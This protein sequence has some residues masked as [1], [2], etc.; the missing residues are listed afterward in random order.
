M[1]FHSCHHTRG[2]LLLAGFQ[3][4]APRIIDEQ[5][6]GACRLPAHFQIDR[7][8]RV[9]HL[10][11][12][13]PLG[14]GRQG[15]LLITLLLLHAVK[16]QAAAVL[17]HRDTDFCAGV[18]LFLAR[19][20]RQFP[21]EDLPTGVAPQTLDLVLI[22]RHRR[23]AFDPNDDFRRHRPQAPLAAQGA[24]I[25]RFLAANRTDFH[26]RILIRA[27]RMAPVAFPPGLFSIVGILRPRSG[28][29][30][31]RSGFAAPRRWRGIRWRLLGLIFLGRFPKQETRQFSHPD[32]AVF[33][34]PDQLQQ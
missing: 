30:F 13:S 9:G 8:H 4:Q 23:T 27:G 20:L 21:L 16:R 24:S 6:F 25:S 29:A 10:L 1:V 34:D 31:S 15:N 33:H 7:K 18:V 12:E 22:R 2:E 17:H 11:D 26:R 14:S 28:P 5:Q 3:N 32:P 19:F